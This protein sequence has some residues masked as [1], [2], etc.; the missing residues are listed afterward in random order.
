MGR[1]RGA[2]TAVAAAATG[3]RRAL[4]PAGAATERRGLLR[5]GRRCGA[6][7]AGTGQLLRG[8]AAVCGCTRSV[9]N[10]HKQSL[11]TVRR[12]A[13]RRPLPVTAAPTPPSNAAWAL[14]SAH[15]P[16]RLAWSAAAADGGIRAHVGTVRPGDE[17]LGGVGGVTKRTDGRRRRGQETE[18][19]HD[20]WASSPLGP[21]VSDRVPLTLSYT[22]R[23]R[24]KYPEF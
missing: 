11:R 4:R 21:H 3:R 23:E 10:Q 17:I 8:D 13:T 24:G 7:A 22:S 14:L 15:N 5:G 9:S 20:P 1:G 19:L 12:A 18:G 16:C 2:V 6:T